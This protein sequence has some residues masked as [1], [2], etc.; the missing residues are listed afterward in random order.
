MDGVDLSFQLTDGSS[1][2]LSLS[3]YVSH[4]GGSLLIEPFPYSDQPK[5]VGFLGEAVFSQ[6]FQIFCYY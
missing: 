5:G 1:L 6:L 2:S 3:L 4:F